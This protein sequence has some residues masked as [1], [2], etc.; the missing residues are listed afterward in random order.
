MERTFG[1][2]DEDEAIH[3]QVTAARRARGV[4]LEAI[5]SEKISGQKTVRWRYIYR[6]KRME[7]PISRGYLDARLRSYRC[8]VEKAVFETHIPPG[9]AIDSSLAAMLT[10]SP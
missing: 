2:R 10:P 7:K 1:A 4:Y 8:R 6:A 3:V 5:L 9:S